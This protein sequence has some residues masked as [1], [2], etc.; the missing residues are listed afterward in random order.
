MQKRTKSNDNLTDILKDAGCDEALEKQLIVLKQTGQ[1]DEF[2]R[3]LAKHK[4]SLL[5]D[6]HASQKRIDCLDFLV[7]KTT[8]ELN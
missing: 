2:L 6:L 3:L 5:A 1:T 8:K 4:T 7:Y